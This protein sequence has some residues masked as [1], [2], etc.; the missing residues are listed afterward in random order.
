[1]GAIYKNFDIK[2]ET[3]VERLLGMSFKG[4]IEMI[5]KMDTFKKADMAAQIRPM[6]DELYLQCDR[7]GNS[8][9]P[10]DEQI[11][12]EMFMYLM[13]KIKRYETILYWLYEIDILIG[14]T[15]LDR[16]IKEAEDRIANSDDE[17][18]YRL[19]MGEDGKRHRVVVNVEEDLKDLYKQKEEQAPKTNEILDM[20]AALTA[21]YF[22]K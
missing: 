19:R 22:G 13:G 20:A 15:E 3:E 10:R 6:I 14:D 11:N 4:S 9:L 18:R 7:Y 1:M 16:M 8:E 2:G 5:H 17:L 12:V 21:K